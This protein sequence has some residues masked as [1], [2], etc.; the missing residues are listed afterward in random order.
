MPKS[1]SFVGDDIHIQTGLFD[2]LI[3][4]NVQFETAQTAQC[5]VK[6]NKNVAGS[7]WQVEVVGWGRSEFAMKHR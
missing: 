5:R 1:K 6:G 3:L 4:I 7:R 2:R